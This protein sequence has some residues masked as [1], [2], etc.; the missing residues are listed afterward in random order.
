MNSKLR[1]LFLIFVI[2]VIE[3][4]FLITSSANAE[5]WKYYFTFIVSNNSGSTL[6]NFP[7]MT[8]I[9]GSEMINSRFLNSSGNNSA[10]KEIST[11]RDF[12]IATDN[13]SLI[14]PS[15]NPYQD[16]EY[17]LYTGYSPEKSSF[18]V[19]TGDGGYITVPDT[20]SLELG[21]NFSLDFT[22]IC[23]NADSTNASGI[24]SHYDAVN[25]GIVAGMNAGTAIARIVNRTAATVDILPSASG[26]YTNLTP[27][28][29][30][31]NWDCVNDPVG[32][33]DD[34]TT[35][36]STASAAYVKDA[37]NLQNPSYAGPNPV[38]TS[39][40]VKYRAKEQTEGYAKP[41]LR[42]NGT[43]TTGT[44]VS[45]G[46]AYT[47]YSE[48]L[49]RPGGGSW[50]TNDIDNLQAVIG[51]VGAVGTTQCTQ[52]Y[53]T[54][55]YTYEVYLD[56]SVTGITT[57]EITT[58]SIGLTGGTFTFSIGASS[59]STPYAG[60]VP[61]SSSAWTILDGN[62]VPYTGSYEHYV[63]GVRQLYYAPNTMISGTTLPDREATGG[64]INGVITWGTNP[65][66]I[67]ITKTG[68]ISYES[69]IPDGSDIINPDTV[70][71]YGEPDDW[72]VTGTFA[73]VLTPELKQVFE[74]AAVNM[75]MPDDGTGHH[76]RN[77]YLIIM[78]G[79]TVAVGFGVLLFTGSVMASIVTTVVLL[80]AVVGTG[81]LDYVLVFT[82]L[83]L[84]IGIYYLIKQ[85]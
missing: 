10:M 57:T 78:I 66:Y 74:D 56:V 72:F 34:T 11:N 69:T 38:I 15:I 6:T 68:M 76:A 20:A 49:A 61:N 65:A 40:T 73:G 46:G 82:A 29:T 53:L 25:G 4:T 7:I 21:N 1:N 26:N 32:A 35:F 33:P 13:I 63:G 64:V 75:G 41:Y 67:I 12:G 8:T 5:S 36:V 23:L 55:A 85:H 30:A 14:I 77:L 58:A 22:N 54:I 79:V 24:I 81:V 45:L 71:E 47:N 2:L 31:N 52:I 43:E 62:T 27:N 60:S 70:G 44:E 50:T 48:L 42:L 84:M 28:G 80:I 17:R 9:S 37:Y 19:I 51:L 39:V 83:V 3:V 59:N 16:I 18:S